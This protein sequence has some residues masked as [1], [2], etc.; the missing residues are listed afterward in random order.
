MALSGYLPPQA[1]KAQPFN[2]NPL[3][4][5][6]TGLFGM[7]R[8]G[9]MFSGG[10]GGLVRPAVMPPSVMPASTIPATPVLPAAAALAPATPQQAVANALMGQ[11][12]QLPAMPSRMQ[13]Y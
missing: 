6:P 10:A 2:Q 8:P 13:A 5:P 12:R 4:A 7:G 3:G 11:R 9:Q 1:I